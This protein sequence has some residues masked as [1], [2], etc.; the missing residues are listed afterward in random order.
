MTDTT[1]KPRT[2]KPIA[3]EE[4]SNPDGKTNL[5]WV[6]VSKADTVYDAIKWI[7]ANGKGDT[8]Y[9]IITI[10]FQDTLTVDSKRVASFG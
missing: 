4:G 9:R 5:T 7:K 2:P 1:R 3:I 6:E 8:T 10:E